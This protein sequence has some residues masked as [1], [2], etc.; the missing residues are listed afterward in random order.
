MVG[1]PSQIGESKH[2]SC[3]KMYKIP[4]HDPEVWENNRFFDG[5]MEHLTH[6]E[7]SAYVMRPE[8]DAGPLSLCMVFLTTT[9]YF[10]SNILE[11]KNL[12]LE[13]KFEQEIPR[14]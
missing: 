6:S 1:H 7:R 9:N 4:I 14:S 5:P 11:R 13:A 12:Q 10:C 8:N 2:N 3:I